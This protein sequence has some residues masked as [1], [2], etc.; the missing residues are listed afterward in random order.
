[1]KT[2]INKT[3]YYFYTCILI[4]CFLLGGHDLFAQQTI[5]G[6]WTAV[7]GMAIQEFNFNN[8]S[9]GSYKRESRT[10]SITTYTTSATS[11]TSR[12]FIDYTIN[13]NGSDTALYA[14]VDFTSSTEMN[15]AIFTQKTDR[16]QYATGNLPPSTKFQKN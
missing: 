11:I 9:T 1:M 13:H 3:P 10:F 6:Q 16:D 12:E 8:D 7:E 2:M 15:I 4:L 14:V 5:E